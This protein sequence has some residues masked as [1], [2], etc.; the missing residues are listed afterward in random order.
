MPAPPLPRFLRAW[1]FSAACW[2]QLRRAG[3]DATVGFDKIAGLDVYYPQGGAYAASVDFNLLKHRSGLL[4]RVL[5]SLKWLDPAH[6]SF[7]ALE[8]VQFRGGRAARGGDQRHGAAARGATGYGVELVNLRVLPIAPGDT[9]TASTSAIGRGGATRPVSSRGLGPDRVIGSVRRYE[10]SPEGPGAA[11]A[12]AAPAEGRSRPGGGGTAEDGGFERLARRLGIANRVRF[13]GY[14]PDMRNAYFAADLLV[15]PTFYDPCSNVVVEA[16]ACGLPVITSRTTA[17]SEMLR[18][19]GANGVCAEGLILDDPHDHTRLAWCL[20]QMMNPARRAA[21]G[22]AA[23]QRGGVDLR[24]SLPGNA[25]DP[26]RGSGAETRGGVT[27]RRNGKQGAPLA[28][29]PVRVHYPFAG[30]PF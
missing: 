24:A 26:D 22:R 20:E 17:A 18:P 28:C 14:C 11:A 23:L 6:P 3:H 10:L 30:A 1:Y 7:L 5:R 9:G 2:Q 12:R 29:A 19:A 15:H 21:C 4:R 16:M 25:G 13:A 8:R 27:H